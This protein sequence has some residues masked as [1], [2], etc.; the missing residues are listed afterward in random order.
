[1]RGATILGGISTLGL[2]LWLVL[3]LARGGMGDPAGVFG[4]TGR[5]VRGAATGWMGNE[6]T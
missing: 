2:L 1:M 5:A 6:D 3:G 4:A